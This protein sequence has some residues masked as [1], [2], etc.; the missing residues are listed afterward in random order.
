MKTKNENALMEHEKQFTPLEREVSPQDAFIKGSIFAML[1]RS[2]M[3][4]ANRKSNKK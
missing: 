2:K 3:K 1:E 4:K